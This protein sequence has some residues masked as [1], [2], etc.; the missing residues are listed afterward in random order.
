MAATTGGEAYSNPQ[1]FAE[2][3]ACVMCDLP[4]ALPQW[5]QRARAS[6]SA[7]NSGVPRRP[8]RQAPAAIHTTSLS[9]PADKYLR[10]SR[11]LLCILMLF[12]ATCAFASG[13]YSGR[14]PRPPGSDASQYELGKAIYLGRVATG[15][16]VAGASTRAQ[17]Q[18]KLAR[19]QGQLPHTATPPAL[20]DLAGRL[21]PPQLDALEYDLRVR[22]K[23]K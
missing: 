16:R 14:T 13:S 4:G 22:Y 9:Y 10:M 11:G 21:T 20:Q 17:Q 12:F 6:A 19:W 1:A 5:L 2:G 3:T 7:S 8:R 18:E 15:A 23:M